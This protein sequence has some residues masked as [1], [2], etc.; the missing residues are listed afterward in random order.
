[1]L[2]ARANEEMENKSKPKTTEARVRRFLTNITDN[3][4]MEIQIVAGRGQQDMALQMQYQ[5]M[6][7]SSTSPKERGGWVA[8]DPPTVLHRSGPD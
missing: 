4:L 6:S 7:C 3:A 2:N 8:A 5:P 1:M